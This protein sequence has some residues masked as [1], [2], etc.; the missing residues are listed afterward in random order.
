MRYSIAL[1]FVYK[2]IAKEIKDFVIERGEKKSFSDVEKVMGLK[3][4]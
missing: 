1:S 4:M 3:K 2:C